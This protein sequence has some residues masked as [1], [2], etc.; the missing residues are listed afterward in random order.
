MGTGSILLCESS[1][2]L[3]LVGVNAALYRVYYGERKQT[4][5]A[6]IERHNSHTVRALNRTRTIICCQF[7]STLILSCLA[8]AFG[9]L[10]GGLLMCD[11]G[12]YEMW[13]DKKIHL[14]Y[15]F[16]MLQGG[17]LMCNRGGYEMW[18]D[19]KSILLMPL[20]CCKMDFFTL[21]LLSRSRLRLSL[22]RQALLLR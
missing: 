7:Q 14:A 2:R 18:W 19:K 1:W 21:C 4:R 10:Q 9:M 20:A 5:F 8:Y 22:C 3:H 16:G 15:A 17:L 12:G 13:W 6:C 11:R